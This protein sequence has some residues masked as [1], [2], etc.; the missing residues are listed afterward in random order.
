M[1]KNLPKM[2]IIYIFWWSTVD[3][4]NEKYYFCAKIQAFFSPY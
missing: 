3:F 1:V 2:P 4:Y